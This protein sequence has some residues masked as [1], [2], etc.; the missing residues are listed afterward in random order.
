MKKITSCI[1]ILALIVIGLPACAAPL[2]AQRNTLVLSW[3]AAPEGCSTLIYAALPS[4][5]GWSVRVIQPGVSSTVV[6]NP[7]LGI[8]F[9]AT[10]R[11][12]SGLESERSDPVT[13]NLVFSG[14]LVLSAAKR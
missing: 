6:T 11:D 10:Y 5:T 12:P 4:D 2:P 7:P 8:V 9:Y 13:N 1:L 3:D 14:P